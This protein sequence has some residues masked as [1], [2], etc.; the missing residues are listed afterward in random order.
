MNNFIIQK[1][2]GL[3][4]FNQQVD[5]FM[6]HIKRV[7]ALSTFKTYQAKLS[8]FVKWWRDAP[9]IGTVKE[10][11]RKLSKKLLKCINKRKK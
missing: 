3:I 6:L 8:I 5:D 11:H 7:K 4:E 10:Q 2:N 9:V 1:N